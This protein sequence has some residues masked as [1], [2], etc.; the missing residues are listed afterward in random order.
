LLDLVD[1]MV[2]TNYASNKR[3]SAGRLLSIDR[4]ACDMFASSG[5]ARCRGRLP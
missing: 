3:A 2:V 4:F 5:L 1:T